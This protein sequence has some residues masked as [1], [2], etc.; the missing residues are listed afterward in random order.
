[1]KNSGRHPSAISATVSPKVPDWEQSPEIDYGVVSASLP[2]QAEARKGSTT[3]RILSDATVKRPHG[4]KYTPRSSMQEWI[5]GLATTELEAAVPVEDLAERNRAQMEI[6]STVMDLEKA[7]PVDIQPERTVSRQNKELQIGDTENADCPDSISSIPNLEITDRSSAVARSLSSHPERR[8][9]ASHASLSSP[10]KRSSESAHCNRSQ[11]QKWS[12]GLAN[13]QSAAAVPDKERTEGQEIQVKFSPTDLQAVDETEPLDPEQMGFVE[14]QRKETRTGVMK[15]ADS[16]FFSANSQHSS[17]YTPPTRPLILD[18]DWEKRK[19]C[20][21]SLRSPEKR[22]YLDHGAATVLPAKATPAASKTAA[23][24]VFAIPELLE[25]I[26]EQAAHT[27]VDLETRK[28]EGQ[29]DLEPLKSFSRKYS[30]RGG[31][32]RTAGVLQLGTVNAHI[33]ET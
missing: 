12:N 33:E 32:F 11:M 31:S 25:M 5:D 21:N 28:T 20:P 14:S 22:P 3:S 16:I 26:L 13:T 30:P 23:N 7:K 9:C 2:L 24:Q 4:S 1:M 17:D 8:A 10:G 18:W 19:F 15:R 27:A 6:S 29:R